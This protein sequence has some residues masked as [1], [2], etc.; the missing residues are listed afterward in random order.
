MDV[1]QH[2]DEGR[3]EPALTVLLVAP[4]DDAL[5]VAIDGEG[6]GLSQGADALGHAQVGEIKQ[7]PVHMQLGE[8]QVL[9]ALVL[10]HDQ[11][12]LV[13]ERGDELLVETAAP[14]EVALQVDANAGDDGRDVVFGPQLQRHVMGIWNVKG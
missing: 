1:A 7:T 14:A 2:A 8:Q 4:L 5:E 13:H 12:A 3:V 9:A 6:E 11:E 10:A